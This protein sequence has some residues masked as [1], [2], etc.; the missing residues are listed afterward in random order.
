MKKIHFAFLGLTLL[1]GVVLFSAFSDKK[2][3]DKDKRDL[4]TVYF[5][6]IPSD[7][8]EDDFGESGSWAYVGTVNPG[9]ICGAQGSDACIVELPASINASVDPANQTDLE[10]QQAFADL[11]ASYGET[12]F[13]YDDATDYILDHV[14]TKKL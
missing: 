7:D 9:A 4:P 5:R 12:D 8:D 13:S 6:Y 14:Q 3:E 11:L 10:M 1:A 2:V